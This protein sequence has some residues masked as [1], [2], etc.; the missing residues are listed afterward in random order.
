[1]N[2]RGRPVKVYA[3]YDGDRFI[4]IGTID[5]LSKKYGYNKNTIGF[6]SSP[7][8]F[9]RTN[10]NGKLLIELKDEEEDENE[11]MDRECSICNADD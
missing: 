9:K 7:T 8:Y 2:N 5:E 11:E 4:D 1:M 10:G 3:F 6:Y